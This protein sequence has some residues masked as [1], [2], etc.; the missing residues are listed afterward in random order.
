MSERSHY[1]RG[2]QDLLI[3]SQGGIQH[4]AEVMPRELAALLRIEDVLLDIR[5]RFGPGA[6][7]ETATLSIAEDCA[8]PLLT[9][10]RDLLAAQAA[11]AKPPKAPKPEAP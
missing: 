4:P 10:I 3:V 1:A 6:M 8:T 2:E 7:A 9:E 11:P 5:D